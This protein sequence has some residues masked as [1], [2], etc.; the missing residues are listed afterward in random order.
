MTGCKAPEV[1]D[2]TRRAVRVEAL[3]TLHPAWQEVASLDRAIA[4]FTNRPPLSGNVAPP[5]PQM[6]T[7]FVPPPDLPAT[8]PQQRQRR[9]QE[10][11]DQYLRQ[12]GE[13]LRLHDE[14]FLTRLGRK[15]EQGAKLQYQKELDA[16]QASIRADRLAQAAIL[17][18][19]ITA[20]RF[21][22][23]AF[24]TQ[25]KVYKDQALLDAQF[26]HQELLSQIASL[27]AQDDALV[28][29][30]GIALAAQT[31]L[32]ARLE[33]LRAE[34]VRQVAQETQRLAALRAERV[35]REQTK[36]VYE[37]DPLPSLDTTPLPPPDER[38]TPLAL[39]TGTQSADAM[40]AANGVVTQAAQRQRLAWTAQ[41]DR[42]IAVIRA[43][44]Q[45]GVEQIARQRGWTLAPAGAPGAIDATDT[46]KPLL[47]AQWRQ[48]TQE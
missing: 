17:D 35:K 31:A 15:L 3:L 27:S 39:P 19:Q 20:L 40:R 22:D 38:E 41:R 1:L 34:A 2:T 6:P 44:T 46:V 33:D 9:A 8:L 16:R 42:L 36:L 48:A 13:T 32:G 47:R 5:L 37:P 10:Y 18:R 23:V 30:A 4:Q 14:T 28:A 25:I 11:E 21:R 26:Q 43:D 29:P 7:G 24:L 45:Q 12:L